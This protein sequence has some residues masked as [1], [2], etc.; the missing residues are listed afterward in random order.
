M[1]QATSASPAMT[2]SVLT[3]TAPVLA[4]RVGR[5][6]IPGRKTLATPHHVPLT[7]RGTVP[8]VAHDVMRDHTEINSLYAGLEDSHAS[9]GI[10]SVIA[11]K[12]APVYKTPVANHESPLKKF[13]CVADDMPLILGPRRFPPIPCPPANTSTSIALLT[14]VG[15][16]QL[17]AA[18][19]VKSIQKLKPDIAIGMVDL[20]NKQ[21]GSK[22]RAKMV[23]RTHAWTQEALEQ[24]YGNGATEENKSKSAFFA[25]VLPLDNAQQSLYLD[26]LESEFRWDISGLALYQSASL[27]FVPESLADLPR[28]LFSEPETPHTILRDVSLGADLLTTPLLGASSDGGIAMQFAFPAPAAL[29]EGKSEPQPLGIDLWLGDHATDTSPLGEGCECY[30]CKNYHRAYIHHLLVAKEMT[31]WALLQVH[32]FHVMDNFFAGVRESIQRGSFEQD[33]ATFARVYASSMPESKGT[34][35]RLRGYQLPAN[36]PNQPRRMPK[37][38]GQL[39]DA[40]QK[41]AESQSEVATPDTDASGLEEHGFAEKL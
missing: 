41:Y 40:I 30:T 4:P 27:G 38:W 17:S 35:P 15:F 5:L 14:S 39:D 22:R 34:G 18:E 24:L 3:S 7:S 9:P 33:V 21:P 36:G 23:D 19:Y 29:Q 8:H 12:D 37:I 20:A 2:F 25:P 1:D 31:A 10:Y 13:I 32:N 6:A 16:T 11:K 28:L 26:D